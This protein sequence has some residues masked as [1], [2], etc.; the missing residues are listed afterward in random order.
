MEHAAALLYRQGMAFLETLSSPP[1]L[2]IIN[3]APHPSLPGLLALTGESRLQQAHRS[4]WLA[5]AAQGLEGV[6]ELEGRFSVILLL[7]SRH[8][9]Q[10]LGWMAAAVRRLHPGGTLICCCPN[11]MGARTYEKRLHALAGNIRSTSKSRCRVFSAR[12]S[13]DIDTTLAAGWKAEAAPHRIATHGLYSRPGLFSWRR[14]DAGSRLLLDHLPVLAGTGMDL[15]CGYGFLATELLARNR[16]VGMLHLV[17]AD[18]HAL[19]CARLNLASYR[20]VR[21]GFHWLDAVAESLPG[22]MDWVVLNPPFHSGRASD[23]ALGRRIIAAACGALRTG[24]RLFLVANRSL[25][26][27]A[28]L[29]SGLRRVQSLYEGEGYKVVHGEK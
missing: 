10:T 24:G 20:H 23:I 3:A 2:G 1:R 19:D 26:Y 4:A 17:D 9:A 13:D 7:A 29:K 11:S 25:P 28:V 6:P 5:L 14:P 18:R 21:T 22:G 8:R 27:E 15:C 16:R 12:R